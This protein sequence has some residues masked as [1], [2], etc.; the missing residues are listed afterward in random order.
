[1]NQR[2][3][4]QYPVFEPLFPHYEN[5]GMENESAI[6]ED[7]Q[8]IL[9]EFPDINTIDWQV[10]RGIRQK[11]ESLINRDWG[12]WKWME[13]RIAT[14]TDKDG[15]RCEWCIS[16]HNLNKNDNATMFAKGDIVVREQFSQTDFRTLHMRCAL[17]KITS[18]QDAL[19]DGKERLQTYIRITDQ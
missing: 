18:L 16:H 6:E 13:V 17:E 11:Y 15:R 14:N 12:R 10:K 1:M 2:D 3:R 4:T 8:A 19:Q 5:I 9:N 7:E